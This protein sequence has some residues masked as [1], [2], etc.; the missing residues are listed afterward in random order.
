MDDIGSSINANDI[1]VVMKSGQKPAILSQNV[2]VGEPEAMDL[3]S[4]LKYQVSKNIPI[5]PNQA[6]Q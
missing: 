1:N 2:S 6:V 3:G 5:D 4:N